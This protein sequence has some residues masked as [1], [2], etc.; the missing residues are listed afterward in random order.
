MW[1]F[2]QVILDFEEKPGDLSHKKNGPVMPNEKGRMTQLISLSLRMDMTS[3]KGG[4]EEWC[5]KRTRCQAAYGPW[6]WADLET[7]A[8][9]QN[10]WVAGHLGQPLPSGLITHVI[11]TLH[12]PLVS[13][14]LAY[15]GWVR[16]AR[17]QRVL[18]TWVGNR[19]SPQKIGTR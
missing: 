5:R 10:L 17:E 11:N 7:C 3:W 9:P 8:Q 19:K 16:P 14:K 13:L 12:L 4:E 2:S 18:P 1:L 15:G 6:D